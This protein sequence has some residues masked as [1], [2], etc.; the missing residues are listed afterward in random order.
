RAWAMTPPEDPLRNH[1][2]A[3]LLDRVTRGGRSACVLRHADAIAAAVFSPQGDRIL[4][5]SQDNT[6]RL[7]DAQ[8]GAP[9]GEPLRHDAAV[10]AVA[11]SPQGDRVLTGSYDGAAR[12]WDAHRGAPLGEPL[13]HAGAVAV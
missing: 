7:W 3:V 2:E 1:Y 5:G 8:R 9:L 13:R 6:A 10:A 11:F 4:T 12:L